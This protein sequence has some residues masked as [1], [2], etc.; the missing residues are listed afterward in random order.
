M[1]LYFSPLYCLQLS[2]STLSLTN[3]V[4]C[5]RKPEWV[6]AL[7]RSEFFGSCVDHSD[8]RKNERNMFCIDCSL[9]FCKHCIASPSHCIRHRWLQI[10]K[11]VYQDVVR[12]QDIQRYLDC[13]HIQTYKINGEKAV[14]L[15]PRPRSKDSKNCKPKG[16]SCC[17]ACGRHIQEFP[18]RYC[19]IAC[20]V[21]DIY[22]E[23]KSENIISIRISQFDHHLSS[24]ENTTENE[25]CSSLTES[26]EVIQVWVSSALKPRKQLHKR[27]G[28]PCRAPLC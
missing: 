12:L 19:S 8:R 7:L 22:K 21:S 17:D 28:V 13:S 24:K 3:M 5:S 16:G 25:S 27:K 1:H 6:T 26:S 4:G 20:K 9:G 10:C 18:N 11:Y 14:H 23:C 15:N 2:N